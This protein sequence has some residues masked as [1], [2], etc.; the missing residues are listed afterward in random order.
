[1]HKPISQSRGV[2]F[3]QAESA[4][5]LPIEPN[6]RGVVFFHNDPLSD[7]KLSPVYQQRILYIL[8]DHI[9]CLFSKGV[10]EDII[11]IVHTSDPS[12]SG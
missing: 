7:I 3:L 11:E 10:V 12:T 9:L 6:F 2:I 1:M 4:V 8:L 5:K